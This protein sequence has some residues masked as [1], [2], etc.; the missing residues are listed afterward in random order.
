MAPGQRASGRRPDADAAAAQAIANQDLFGKSLKV[1][2][3]AAR[4]YGTPCFVLMADRSFRSVT[5]TVKPFC[6][7]CSTHFAQQPQVGVVGEA[8][9]V[10]VDRGKERDDGS[11]L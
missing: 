5:C 8:A 4:Q 11:D 10:F 1:A 2:V 7:M 3:E 6:F 9:L